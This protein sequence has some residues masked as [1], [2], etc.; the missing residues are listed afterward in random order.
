MGYII[1]TTTTS[2]FHNVRIMSLTF[3]MITVIIR[4][5][6]FITITTV[7]SVVLS[8]I[9]II[10][11]LTCFNYDEVIVIRNLSTL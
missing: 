10:D 3:Q 9:Q 8:T 6:R 11:W 1:I 7:N 4:N 5:I 2:F